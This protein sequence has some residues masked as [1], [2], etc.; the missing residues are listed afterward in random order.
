[1]VEALRTLRL[2]PTSNGPRVFGNTWPTWT[3]TWEDQLAQQEMEKDEREQ[4]ARVQNRTKLRPSSVEI[5]HMEAAI[6]WPGRYLVELPQLIRIVQ[7]V[8]LGRSRFRDMD[9]SARR[10]NLPGRLVRRWHREGVDLIA[11]GLRRDAVRIF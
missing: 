2:L 11:A 9:W 1:L 5:A 4:I 8:T 10:L 6:G 3:Y 7:V